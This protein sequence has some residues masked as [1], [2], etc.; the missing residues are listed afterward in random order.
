[1][2]SMSARLVGPR[3]NACTG[4]VTVVP[5]VDYFVY[6]Y[7]GALMPQ[8]HEYEEVCKRC[9][10][11]LFTPTP[12]DSGSDTDPSTDIDEGPSV[13]LVASSICWSTPLPPSPF[14]LSLFSSSAFVTAFQL[15]SR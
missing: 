12:Q 9:S 1:M 5:G 14:P 4:W 7:K 2:G 11:A 10:A 15:Q 6:S 13:S 8:E 3:P